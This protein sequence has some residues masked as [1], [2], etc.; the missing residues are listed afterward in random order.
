MNLDF[1][2]CS[3][4]ILCL[5]VFTVAASAA[6]ASCTA[7]LILR[8]DGSNALRVVTDEVRIRRHQ[9]L[10]G[11][12]PLLWGLVDEAWLPWRRARQGGWMA[13]RAELVIPGGGTRTSQYTARAG[14]NRYR[15]AEVI[16]TCAA[17][18][19]GGRTYDVRQSWGVGRTEI[20]LTRC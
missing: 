7:D 6:S 11:R 19:N 10:L 3:A 20:S 18:P 16:Y 4:L 13:G 12:S 17:G 5:S 9:T 14:C 2:K 15:Q 1:T 8:N